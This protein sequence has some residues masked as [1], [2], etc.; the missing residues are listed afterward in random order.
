MLHTLPGVYGRTYVPADHLDCSAVPVDGNELRKRLGCPRFGSARYLSEV[1]FPADH[2]LPGRSERDSAGFP[3]KIQQ[4]EK[5]LAHDV[6][7]QYLVLHPFCV[8]AGDSVFL[9][10]VHF[11]AIRFKEYVPVLLQWRL[12]LQRSC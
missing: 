9:L 2:L 3:Q 5:L 8:L 7:L 1:I 12:K 11:L 4:T 6:R 10:P